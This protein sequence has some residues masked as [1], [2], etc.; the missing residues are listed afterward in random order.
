MSPPVDQVPSDETLPKQADVVVIGGGIIGTVAAYELAIRGHSVALLE[1]GRIA[2]EQSSRNWGWC[3]VHGRAIPA[4]PLATA[5]LRLWGGMDREIGRPTGFRQSGVMTVLQTEADR[6]YWEHWLEEARPYQLDGRMLS[7]A[8]VAERLPGRSSPGLGGMWSAMDGRAEPARAAPAIAAAARERGATLH[9]GCAARGLETTAGA[10]SA[11]VTEKGRIR[12]GAVLLAGGAWASMFCRRH[13]IRFPQSGVVATAFRTEPGA[14][15]TPGGV[16]DGRYAMRLRDDGGYTVALAGSGRV[17]LTPQKFRY[18]LDFIPLFLK[19]RK[20]LTFGLGRS[21]VE[22]PEAAARW[23][24]DSASPFER[25]RVLDPAPGSELVEAALAMLRTDYP[26][27]AQ[28]RVAQ[29]WGGLIDSTPDA[30]PVIS[31]VQEVP[32]FY[33]AAGFSGLGFGLGPASGR[34]AAD[35]ITGAAPIVDPAPYRLARFS[36]R[37]QLR[38]E[39]RM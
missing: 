26:A 30:Q 22:G 36:D 18:A 11:V 5:S 23:S 16:T 4:L 7:G 17:E 20:K 15:V 14:V 2:G 32:G 25:L 37:S 35:L 19:R 6:A 38:P 12:T 21:F 10:V 24:L 33:L 13:G 29:A 39:A 28:A 9:Q 1:K 34:L 3:R 27:L 31:Q 8:E